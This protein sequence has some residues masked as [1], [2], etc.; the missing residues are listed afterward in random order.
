MEYFKVNG[1]TKLTGTFH[2]KGNKNSALP[3]L[4]SVL[5]SDQPIT[6][7]NLPEIEDVHVMLRILKDLGVAV[8]H[9]EN[10]VYTFHAKKINT[11]AIDAK[12]GALIRSSILFLGPLLARKKEASLPV[13]GGDVIGQ[14]RLDPHFFAMKKLGAE[15]DFEN[16]FRVTCKKLT[17]TF[18]Y[19][20][21]ASV[22]ATE[23]LIM[24]A[25]TAEG[26][27]TVYNAACEPHVQDLCLFLNHIGAKITGIGTN[28]LTI[29][30]VGQ[31]SGG[32]WSI[33]PDHIEVGSIV[34]LA[35]ITG[36]NITVKDVVPDDYYIIRNMFNKLGIDFHFKGND[37]IVP[38]EQEL[39][40]KA[41]MNGSIP[42][43]AD[44]IWPQFPSDL[45]S[46]FIVMATQAAGTVLIFEKLFE[47]RMF[48]VD[49]LIG[50]GAKII[51]CDPHRVVVSGPASLYAG[52]I[53]SPD[54]R[55][56]MAMLIAA[57]AA[58][59]ESK[60]QNIRQIDRGY[61]TID[62][63]LNAMGASIQRMS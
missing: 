12:L 11:C 18:I 44:G 31:L 26:T 46:I 41:D 54:I 22:T 34:G 27:T 36:S 39:V 30:G 63:R 48:F 2:P 37:L 7:K 55:A 57:L 1:P 15:V 32:E 58:N 4:A 60:I 53:S 5:L 14:R 51:L 40:I 25:V 38:A 42:T 19:L 33:R 6:L 49:R 29:E 24:A 17:G 35:A 16:S 23:N 56:G 13:P 21:E 61:E 62:Q 3:I 47:S 59:G 8:K 28:R 45:V 52:N 10:N 20:E 43:I 9:I 50:M